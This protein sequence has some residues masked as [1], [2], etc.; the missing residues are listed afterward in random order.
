V[1]LLRQA[2]ALGDFLV[3]GLNS[4]ASVQRLKG[5]SRPLNHA[6][7]R[8]E[9]LS[10][11][12]AVDAVA[13]FEEDTPLDLIE[14]ILPDVLI[15]GDDYAPEQVVGRAEVEAAGGRLVLVPLVEGHSTT[16]LVNRADQRELTMHAAEPMRAPHA[17][18]IVSPVGMDR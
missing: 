13:L 11:L 5:P 7:A 16:G 15:K 3:V 4:D 1:R 14:A 10:A 2:A 9:V 6:E 8:G 18:R 12:E 17:A